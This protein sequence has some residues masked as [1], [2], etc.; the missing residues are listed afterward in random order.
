MVIYICF[1]G[2]ICVSSGRRNPLEKGLKLDEF[3]KYGP[4][5]NWRFSRAC[6]MLDVTC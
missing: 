6:R 5:G 4:E 3:D 2:D 1:V